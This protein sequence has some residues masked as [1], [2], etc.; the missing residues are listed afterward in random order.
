MARQLVE[1]VNFFVADID[2]N[3]SQISRTFK[4]H[5]SMQESQHGV[6]FGMT[7]IETKGCR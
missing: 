6:L 5:C 7:T 2:S 1:I 4:E 3:N